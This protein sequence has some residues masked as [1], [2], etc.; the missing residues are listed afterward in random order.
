MTGVS[1]GRNAKVYLNTGPF[2]TPA[3]AEIPQI[4]DLTQAGAW[5]SA[6]ASTRESAVKMGVKTLADLSVTCKMKFVPGDTNQATIIDAFFSPTATVDVM[7]LN[8]PQTVPGTYGV[9]YTAQVSQRDEDQGL[10]V[11]VFEGLKFEPTPSANPPS[12]AKVVGS[13]PVFT[14]L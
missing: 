12:S 4:S 11:G 2:G 13:A 10:G 3:W 5:D 7:V 8:G 6:E 1:L 9:R 14:T